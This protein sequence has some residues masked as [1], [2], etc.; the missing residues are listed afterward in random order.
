MSQIPE[1]ILHKPKKKL[2][3]IKKLLYATNAYFLS[4]IFKSYSCCLFWHLFIVQ[5]LT[6]I[7]NLTSI[8]YYND[9]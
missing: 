5:A 9:Y 3:W 6:E 8:D 2:Y 1:D 7:V 4:A